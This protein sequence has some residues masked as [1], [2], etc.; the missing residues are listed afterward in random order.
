MKDKHDNQ[1]GDLLA[2]TTRQG[3]YA[4]RQRQIGRRQRSYWL[5]DAEAEAVA[6]L[7]ERLRAEEHTG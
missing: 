3:R 2:S 7:I 5:T 4:E 6:A 1:T